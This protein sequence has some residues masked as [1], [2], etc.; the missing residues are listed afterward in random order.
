MFRQHAA[1][2]HV[3]RCCDEVVAIAPEPADVDL[4]IGVKAVAHAIPEAAITAFALTYDQLRDRDDVIGNCHGLIRFIVPTPGTCAVCEACAS[5]ARR[6][7]SGW[8]AA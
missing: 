1:R 2:G 5:R 6:N 3:L 7:C 4:G 8:S